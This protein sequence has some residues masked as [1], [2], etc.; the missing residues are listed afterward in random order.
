MIFIIT[1]VKDLLVHDES[2]HEPAG[3]VEDG[4][5]GANKG[6]EVVVQDERLPER[7]VEAGDRL[8]NGTM[9]T[10]KYRLTHQI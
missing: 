2:V 6:K 10:N 8:Q 1:K 7:L 9:I 3:A 4:A 5:D